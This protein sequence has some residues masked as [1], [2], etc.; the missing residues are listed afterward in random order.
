MSPRLTPEENEKLFGAAA[1]PFGHGH[2]YR[3]RL[4]FQERDAALRRPLVL[5]D[6]IEK[7][8][9]SLRSELDHKNLNQEVPGLK[10]QPVTTENLARYIHQRV[11]ETRPVHRVR[12]HERDDFFAEYSGRREIISSACNFRSTPR[13]ACT[14]ASLPPKKTSRFT[15]NAITRGAT[16]IAT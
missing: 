3:A 8:L 16:A 5:H 4:T 11:S 9:G 12:L 10:D 2:N 6:E 14:A 1:S 13:I 7:C 15:A